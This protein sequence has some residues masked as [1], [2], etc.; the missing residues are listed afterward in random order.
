MAEEL[1]LDTAIRDWVLVPLSVVMVLIGVLRYFVSKLMR[2][3]SSSP[4]PD[5]KLVKEGYVL[6]ST[7]P[8]LHLPAPIPSRS[9]PRFARSERSRSRNRT[10][11]AQE[12]SACESVAYCC[13]CCSCLAVDGV[14]DVRVLLLCSQVVIRARNLRTSAQ[15]IPAKAFKARKSYYTNEVIPLEASEFTK[16]I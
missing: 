16:T 2:S 14:A 10:G 5:P 9:V 15:F 1:V 3:P 8:S 13:C 12:F 7:S 6:S 4:S 11:I